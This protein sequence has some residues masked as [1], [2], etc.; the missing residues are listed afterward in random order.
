VRA[1]PIITLVRDT[2]YEAL[3]TFYFRMISG[4]E[5]EVR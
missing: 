3:F 1:R 2:T 5:C 4:N